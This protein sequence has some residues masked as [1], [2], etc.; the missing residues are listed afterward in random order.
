MTPSPAVPTLPAAARATARP[1]L[2]RAAAG[3]FTLIEM[4]VVIGIL[5]L[6][7]TITVIGIGRYQQSGRITDA[8]ARIASLSLIIEG[9]ADD[10]G[11]YP[12]SRLA[13]L[14]VTDANEVNEG[15]EALVAA[16]FSK[17]HTGSRPDDDWLINVDADRAD[18]LDLATGG[19]GLNELQD[20]WE[21][22]FVYI[23]NGDYDREQVYR[24]TD[25]DAGQVEDVTVRARSNALTETYYEFEGFQ[26]VSAGPD[27]LWGTE[28]DLAN[29]EADTDR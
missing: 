28:D 17:S 9:Y 27:G 23:V 21:N 8:R 22:P 16:L 10:H 5:T 13:Q 26:L 15:I 4:L 2:A 3:G 14:G 20:P 6:L 19:S 24:L 7:M 11:D 1:A 18:G 12:P 29:F 25:V